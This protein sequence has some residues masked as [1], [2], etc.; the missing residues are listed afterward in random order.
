M[1]E[2]NGQTRGLKTEL[3]EINGQTRGLKKEL[4]EING[5]TNGQTRGLKTELQEI[6]GQTRG[7]KTELEGIKGQTMTHVHSADG[8]GTVEAQETAGDDWDAATIEADRD[9]GVT[10]SSFCIE[11]H[12]HYI[13]GAW[14]E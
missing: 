1:E 11:E 3:V 10:D 12:L 6:N 9:A 7:F 8:N 2:I 14:R 5:Q 4:V 13:D